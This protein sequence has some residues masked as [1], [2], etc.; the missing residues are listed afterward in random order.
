MLVR[1]R[2]RGLSLMWNT[3]TSSGSR[4]FT[5]NDSSH[6]VAARPVAAGVDPNARLSDSKKDI[7]WTWAVEVGIH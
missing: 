5:R 7:S 6:C 2:G 3:P 4:L 1:I